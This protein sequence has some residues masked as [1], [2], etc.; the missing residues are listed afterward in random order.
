MKPIRQRLSVP[1][2][3][4]VATALTLPLTLPAQAAEP[5]PPKGATQWRAPHTKDVDKPASVPAGNRSKAL[6]EHYRKSSDRAFTTSGDATGFHLLVAGEKDG[7]AWKT[8]ATL[9]EP[10]FDTDGWIG[11]ACLTASGKRAAVAYAP[12][13]FTNKPE[14][15]ARGAFTALVDL[16]TGKVTKLPFTASLAYFSPGCGTGEQAVFTQLSDD[17]DKSQ[18]SRL[19]R[20]DAATGRQ[21]APLTYP[22]EVTSAVPTRNGIVAAHGNRLVVA[23]AKG[24]LTEIAATRTV[25]FQLT[26]DSAGGV[27]YIDRTKTSSTQKTSTGYALHLD[28]ARL[29]R[30]HARATTVAQGR[31][32]D[33]DLASSADGTVFV[34]GRAKTTG[35][36]PRAVRNPG[37]IAK[38]ALISSHGHAAVTTAWAD[39]EAAPLRGDEAAGA[40]TARMTM[41]LLH[42][43]TTVTLDSRPGKNRIGGRK[44]ARQGAAF[45]PALP[46]PEKTSGGP[47]TQTVRLQ[48]LSASPTGPSEDETERTCGV[49]RNDVRKMA[50]QPTPRQVEWAVDQAV[51]GKLDFYRS[52]DWKGTGMGGYQP[53]GLFP[54]TV[55]EGDPNGR[56]D[57]EDGTNDRWHIPA[58]ILLGVTAQES[59]MWQAG[60]YAV[61]GVTANSLIGNFYGIKYSADGT[62]NDPWKIDW[63]KADCGYGITQATDGMRLPGHDQPTKSVLQQEAVAL[64]YTANIAAGAQILS[65]K[66]NETRKAGLKV[67]DGHPQ[68]IENWFFALWA[69]NSG[70]YADADSAGH[71]GVGWTNNPANPLW[72]ANRL[73]FLESAVGGD[74]YSHA[75]HPQDWPYE[76]KVIGWAARPISAMFAPG[77]MQAGYRPA[78]WNTIGDRSNA[79]PPVDLFCDSSNSCEPSKI[80]D[81]DSNDP[82]QGAC[83]LD[84]GT[85]DTNPHWLHCWWN[86]SVQ[87]K[88][89]TT[90]AQCGNQVHRFNTSYPEQPDA[91]SY[92]PRCSSGLASD[93]LIVDD[94]DD[95]VTPAGSAGRSCG[96]VKSDGTFTLS[97]HAWNGTYPGKMDTHQIGAGYGN[98]FWFAHT[99][100]P[101]S[102][103]KADRMEV[104]G[105]WK[106]GK[107]VPGGQAKVYAHVPDHGAQTGEADYRI[108]TAFGVKTKTVSQSANQSNKW[109]DLGAYRFNDSIPEV[110]LSNFNSGGTGDK[111]IAYDA[112]AF[113]PGNYDGMPNIA[114][115]DP[116]VN[117]PQPGDL[118]TPQDMTPDGV[119][120][121]DPLDSIQQQYSD[122]KHTYVPWCAAKPFGWGTSRKIWT[123]R[124]EGCI[125]GRFGFVKSVNGEVTGTATFEFQAEMKLYSDEIGWNTAFKFRIVDASGEAATEPIY[126]TVD[127]SCSL[128]CKKNGPRSDSGNLWWEYGLGDHHVYSMSQI[129]NWGESRPSDLAFLKWSMRGEI[130]GVM[131]SNDTD[132]T[133]G[134][135]A[136]IRCD[137]TVPQAYPGCVFDRYKPTY[138]MNSKKFPAAAA[139]AWLVQNKLP[140]HFGSKTLGTPLT[141][142]GSNVMSASD[143]TK[144]QSTANR[145]VICPTSWPRNQD[146][147]L[148]PELNE[149]D[150]PKD[151]R[152]SCDEFAFAASYDSAGMANGYNP[153]ASG[154]EC[155]QTYAKKGGDGVWHLLSDPRYPLPEWNEKCGRATISNNQNTQSMRPFGQFIVRNRLTDKDQYWLDL[156]GFTP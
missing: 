64:D 85:S 113:V 17:G 11:N 39:G 70:F 140:G 30:K 21:D 125:K 89:C 36:L 100:Q 93:A 65:Q 48:P 81:N 106:L 8:A 136:Q 27:T 16:A 2:V 88:N 41:R 139:H 127:D 151:D 33:W 53:Q 153:V 133:S 40:R 60:R 95:G 154:D 20:V 119:S 38:G 44:A 63:S 116:D 101:E 107:A 15:M 138:V 52:P 46:R 91:N 45:S 149:G 61:P 80:G 71:Q 62:Q 18:R 79:K 150:P 145:E 83:T 156:D 131:S 4:L 43:G 73:P 42:S 57:T 121:G 144:K 56:L 32:T 29:G 12:R 13:T 128:D 129:W 122:P 94:V 108:K 22:G 142:L 120:I 90:G 55:L 92:P 97:Y 137:S 76:E 6:G 54:A 31:L 155:L 124:T 72:K 24:R 10:G 58:Q 143:P 47:S 3:T 96:P 7:Y 51:V 77:D 112:V 84:S 26:V 109:V 69:Y 141:Y 134:A 82:G 130:G 152:P 86:K 123:N 66:W 104:T 67:N 19:I 115:S 74:D 78:W 117:S 25:P 5:A 102:G 126:L 68:W 75:A 132:V 98:H 37:H 99:R 49:A 59:N 147:T 110:S 114:F 148:S 28:A 118:T 111:D 87:W 35:T 105:T 103:D 146:V 23:R 34:T 1:V 14:L 50:F 9:S 135:E